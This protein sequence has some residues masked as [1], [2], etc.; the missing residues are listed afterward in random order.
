MNVTNPTVA[1][2]SWK[3]T[4]AVLRFVASEP[5]NV[6]FAVSE[7]IIGLVTLKVRVKPP[8]TAAPVP[9][10][11]VTMSPK[12]ELLGVSTVFVEPAN[13]SVVVL[14]PLPNTV[15]LP[16]VPAT[17]V[18]PVNVPVVLNVT[19]SALADVTPKPVIRAIATVI[20]NDFARFFMLPPGGNEV[21]NVDR[22]CC[23]QVK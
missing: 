15:E 18:P 8:L 17:L 16:I 23:V 13:V 4:N 20:K 2:G 6:P 9:V 22:G 5:L 11:V 12:L 7:P 14:A 19:M 1:V 10:E 3:K 21:T